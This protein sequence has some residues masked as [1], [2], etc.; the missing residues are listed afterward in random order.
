[1]RI[2]KLLLIMALALE[3]PVYPLQ[4]N[5]SAKSK[6]AK[7]AQ[8][9]ENETH[10]DRTVTR[11]LSRDHEMDK[12]MRNRT[13]AAKQSQSDNSAPPKDSSR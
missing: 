12:L 1:M 9:Q 2:P 11:M 4:P 10:I 5:H 3:V 6:P 13:K 8:I 7:P